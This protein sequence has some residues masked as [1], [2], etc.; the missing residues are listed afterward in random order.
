MFLG[1]KLKQ[2][3][4]FNDPDDPCKILIATDAIGMGLNLNIKRVIFYKLTKMGSVVNLVI[5]H[6]GRFALPRS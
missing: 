4:K 6:T 2:A 1:A 5:M 3:A